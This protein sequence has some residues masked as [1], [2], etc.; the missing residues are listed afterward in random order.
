MRRVKTGVTNW[1]VTLR[2]AKRLF[3]FRDDED[4]RTYYGILGHSRKVTGVALTSQCLMSNHLHM[5]PR[6]DSGQLSEFMWRSGK[7]FADY[8]N[9][10]YKMAGHAF[11]QSYYA[12][13]IPTSFILHRVTRY[14]HLNPVRGGKATRPEDYPWSSCNLYFTG[15]PGPFPCD[16]ESVLR[17]FGSHPRSSREAYRQFVKEDL[18]RRRAITPAKNPAIELWQEQYHWLLEFAEERKAFLSPIEPVLAATYWAHR[19]GIPPRAIVKARGLADGREVYN[20]LRR[21]ERLLT[22][23]PN[24]LAA[25]FSLG[26]VA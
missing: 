22:E 1:H 8:H 21:L 6:A 16:T 2:G 17:D 25:L 10:K 9:K 13:P 14:I 23:R 20:D 3:L 24:L 12:K 18:R 4:Y 19:L 7:C 5:T 15:E 26:V 11:E